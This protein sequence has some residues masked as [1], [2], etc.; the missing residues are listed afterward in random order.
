MRSRGR[1][2]G[3]LVANSHAQLSYTPNPQGLICRGGACAGMG[4]SE[5]YMIMANDAHAAYQCALRYQISGD[6]N[7]ANK[8]VQ[9]M[10]ACR[11][12]DE[13]HR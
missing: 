11:H 2:V 13:H 4:Y 9:I 10:D 6:T 12:P 5:N 7:Y 3:I 1:R 8:S